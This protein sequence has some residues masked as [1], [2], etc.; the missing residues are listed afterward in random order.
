MQMHFLFI[1]EPSLTFVRQWHIFS[2]I[3]TA[4]RQKQKNVIKQVMGLMT[5]NVESIGELGQTF[6]DEKAHIV[7]MQKKDVN[8]GYTT[9]LIIAVTNVTQ[10]TRY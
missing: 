3:F 2:I 8:M 5:N 10:V 6:K 9:T 7:I 1:T 4:Q